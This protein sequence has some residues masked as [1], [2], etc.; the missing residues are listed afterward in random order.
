MKKRYT[1][2]TPDQMKALIG[3]AQPAPDETQSMGRFAVAWSAEYRRTGALGRQ[4]PINMAYVQF[5]TADGTRLCYIGANT[6]PL[7]RLGG[8]AYQQALDYCLKNLTEASP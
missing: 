1:I 2:E 8:L 6:Y 4:Q 5:S 7:R 3:A